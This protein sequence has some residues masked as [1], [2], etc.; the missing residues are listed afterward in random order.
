MEKENVLHVNTEEPSEVCDESF[1]IVLKDEND[2][3]IDFD[4]MDID[5]VENQWMSEIFNTGKYFNVQYGFDLEKYLNLVDESNIKEHKFDVYDRVN[6][7]TIELTSRSN[8]RV[9][10]VNHKVLCTYGEDLRT[11]FWGFLTFEAYKDTEWYPAFKLSLD[12]YDKDI[13]IREDIS[14]DNGEDFCRFLKGLLKCV[15]YADRDEIVERMIHI[16]ETIDKYSRVNRILAEAYELDE[17]EIQ[18]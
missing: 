12:Y 5:W 10:Q 16:S 11:L 7:K 1:N 3:A 2:V 17:R 4:S 6:E 13:R 18:D 8:M 9:C 14:F 15:I